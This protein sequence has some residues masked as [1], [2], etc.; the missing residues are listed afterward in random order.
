M[1]GKTFCS[2]PCYTLDHSIG[3]GTCSVVWLAHHTKLGH[4]VAIKFYRINELIEHDLLDRVRQE[5]SIMMQIS[6]PFCV[7]L[8]DVYETEN[9][10]CLIL[11]Y[12]EGGSLLDY[13]NSCNGLAERQAR[14]IFFELVTAL[15][16]LHNTVNI[17]YRDLKLENIIMD[18][19]LNVRLS[20]FGVS[21][22]FDKNNPQMVTTCGSPAYTAPE[23]LRNDPYG[24]SI[25]IWSLGAALYALISCDFPFNNRNTAQLCNQILN[26]DV[27]FPDGFSKHLKDLLSKMLD[28]DPLKRPTYEE[29]FH[30]KWMVFGNIGSNSTRYSFG[31]VKQHI[32]TPDL[33]KDII[34]QISSFGYDCNN[35]SNDIRNNIRN[36]TVAV[37]RALFKITHS[38]L[39]KDL[40]MKEITPIPLAKSSSHQARMRSNM[41]LSTSALQIKQ[42]QNRAS[43]RSLINPLG[44]RFVP[45]NVKT[46]TKSIH[47]SFMKLSP[48]IKNI[49]EELNKDGQSI[50]VKARVRPRMLMRIHNPGVVPENASVDFSNPKQL[51]VIIDDESN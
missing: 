42:K 2:V 27:V 24:P 26:D 31:F 15:H 44:T 16:Y 34:T 29:L 22:V 12:V 37:Y 25:D 20:D 39:I 3:E 38:K 28:K 48:N 23:I 17:A 45:L 6:H 14:R 8:Y 41:F 5:I 47:S 7:E 35:L 18:K 13:V 10:I 36:E 33:D 9:L 4:E 32:L 19:F 50:N 51:P 43:M 21:T 46:E 30:H 11:E 49:N 40:E 1:E